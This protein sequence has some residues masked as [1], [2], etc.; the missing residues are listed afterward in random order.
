MSV[1]AIVRSR[2][3]AA[4]VQAH[5]LDGDALK[6]R[7]RQWDDDDGCAAVRQRYGGVSR[8]QEKRRRWDDDDDRPVRPVHAPVQSPPQPPQPPQPLQPPRTSQPSQQ[9]QSPSALAAPRGPIAPVAPVRWS[10]P[11]PPPRVVSDALRAAIEKAAAT[12]PPA[13]DYLVF[14]TETT[15]IKTHDVVIQCAW[16]ICASDGRTLGVY[17]R[18]WKLP[19]GVDISWG[20]YNTHKISRAKVMRE[21]YDPAGEILRFLAVIAAMR[22]RRLRCVAHNAAFDVRLINQTAKAWRL[23]ESCDI[24]DTFCT[25]TAGKPHTKLVNRAGRPKPP[26]NTELYTHLTGEAPVGSLHDALV[27]VGVTATSFRLGRERGW[28]T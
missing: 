2:F 3:F 7:A 18:L 26:T 14:D 19:P 20:A 8:A 5:G 17:N 4:A 16:I 24:G 11:P 6:H 13:A 22:A 9:L 23:N 25:L 21:G 28:W 27:D 1:T 10:L 15:G 12:L